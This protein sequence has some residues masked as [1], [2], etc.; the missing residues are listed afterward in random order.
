MGK[1]VGRIAKV[2]SRWDRFTQNFNKIFKTTIDMQAMAD[3]QGF[4][5]LSYKTPYFLVYMGITHR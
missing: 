3:R 5:D 1:L 4:E 2:R